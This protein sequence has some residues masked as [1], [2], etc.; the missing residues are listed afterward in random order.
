MIPKTSLEKR[1]KI[2]ELQTAVKKGNLP[3]ADLNWLLE[4]AADSKWMSYKQIALLED[5]A[6]DWD[7]YSPE[8]KL[9]LVN[10][11]GD[12]QAKIHGNRQQIDIKADIT[13][14]SFQNMFK[15]PA[16]VVEADVL[17]TKKL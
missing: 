5:V 13:L 9:K 16:N 7:N 6:K 17:E 10:A 1:Q 3:L 8:F 11:Y 14:Q 12:A 4:C 2:K 15:T